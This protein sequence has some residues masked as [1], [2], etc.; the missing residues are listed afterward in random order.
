MLLEARNPLNILLG[1]YYRPDYTT[2]LTV[3]HKIRFTVHRQQSGTF[4]P[5]CFD[6]RL[7]WAI[8]H[9]ETE[10]N[11]ESILDNMLFSSGLIFHPFESNTL[12]VDV[13]SPFLVELLKGPS[14][15]FNRK[16]EMDKIREKVKNDEIWF[17]HDSVPPIT[18]QNQ[19]IMCYDAD[20]EKHGSMLDPVNVINH[21][22]EHSKKAFKSTYP[23]LNV[24][25]QAVDISIIGGMDKKQS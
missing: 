8:P 21:C 16:E 7:E 14:L 4:T 3:I 1:R 5:V 22:V 6:V 20:K 9:K 13:D 18:T 24:D 2:L 11:E 12:M 23:E 19:V 15:G 10:R 25:W 17:S